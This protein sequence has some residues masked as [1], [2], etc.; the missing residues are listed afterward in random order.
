MGLAKYVFVYILLGIF[1]ELLYLSFLE[2]F[3]TNSIGITITS[4]FGL[5]FMPVILPA[6]YIYIALAMFIPGMEEF[7]T[8]ILE[9]FRT[10]I[11]IGAIIIG[12]IIL[13]IIVGYCSEENGDEEVTE[14]QC[15]N[16]GYKW[17]GKDMPCP[18][19]GH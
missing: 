14:W 15:M 12:V 9:G 18:N 5:V 7:G 11:T 16:C 10:V 13:C 4:I 2:F 3:N 8:S 19:C 1:Y 6:T 17:V